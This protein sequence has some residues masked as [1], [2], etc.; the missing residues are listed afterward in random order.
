MEN[1]TIKYVSSYKKNQQIFLNKR[2]NSNTK[3]ENFESLNF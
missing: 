3:I 2:D 1:V